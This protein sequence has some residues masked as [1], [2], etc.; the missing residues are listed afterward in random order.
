MEFNFSKYFFFIFVGNLVNILGTSKL[1]EPSFLREYD[2]SN[3]SLAENRKLIRLLQQPVP[4]FRERHLPARV[5]LDSP[6]LNFPSHHF[7]FLQ[8]ESS[9]K[10]YNMKFGR[11]PKLKRTHFIMKFRRRK[12]HQKIARI[13]RTVLLSLTIKRER[14]SYNCHFCHNTQKIYWLK[15]TRR[16]DSFFFFFFFFS[17]SLNTLRSPET[18]EKMSRFGKMSEKTKTSSIFFYQNSGKYQELDRN[19]WEVRRKKNQQRWKNLQETVTFK[20]PRKIKW[21]CLNKEYYEKERERETSYKPEK[22]Y[23]RKGLQ[24]K[25]KSARR[26][27]I[28]TKPP[29]GISEKSITAAR[30]KI[31][32]KQTGK[33]ENLQKK[34][35][36]IF[37]NGW[38]LN[39]FSFRPQNPPFIFP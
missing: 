24:N 39:L 18:Q 2:D 12:S 1:I 5:I 6:H 32:G 29:N 22:I 38:C 37:F 31:P 8:K 14:N 27:V 26:V 16:I 13:P 25:K 30:Q 10:C 36:R 15:G 33:R 17:F 34:K 3:F 35:R 11:T 19:K 9:G 7:F 21:K 23:R 20:K 28:N 4:A